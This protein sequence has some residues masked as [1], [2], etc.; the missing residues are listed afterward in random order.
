MVQIIQIIKNLDTYDFDNVVFYITTDNF[1]LFENNNDKK[2]ILKCVKFSNK[3][4]ILRTIWAQMILPILLVLNRIDV[5]FCPGNISPIFNSKKKL[6]WIHTIGPFEKNFISSFA[7]RERLI[8]I[9]TKY[10]MIFSSYTSDMVI[11]DSNYTRDL[12]VRKFNQKIEKSAVI[13]SGM[14]SFLSQLIKIIH[15]Y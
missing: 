3:S 1:H 8:L 2:I 9:I 5:L 7:F 12:F 13:H 6:Q 14:M 15:K 4:I 11:F 10:L